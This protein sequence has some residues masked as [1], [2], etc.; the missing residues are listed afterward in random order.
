MLFLLLPKKNSSVEVVKRQLEQLKNHFKEDIHFWQLFRT[1][2][3]SDENLRS[4]QCTESLYHALAYAKNQKQLHNLAHTL[5]GF[6]D[7][8]ESEAREVDAIITSAQTLTKE[9]EDKIVKDI[10]ANHPDIFKNIAVKIIPKVNPALLGG[11]TFEFEEFYVD[12]SAKNRLVDFEE[13]VFK[14]IRAHFAPKPDGP[15][16]GWIIPTSPA[17]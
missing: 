14:K 9:E 1:N 6:N 4:L 2:S 11:Y 7:I 8:V 5:K 12:N 17:N 3:I 15:N 13:F 16:S 10:F